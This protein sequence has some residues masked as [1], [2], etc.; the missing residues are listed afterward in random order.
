M[1]RL[2]LILFL[3][4]LSF[5]A[6]AQMDTEHWFAPMADFSNPGTPNQYLYLSTNE[7]T[8]FT[9]YVYSKNQLITTINNLSKGNP[10][11]YSIPRD[12][13]ITSN[14]AEVNNK[15]ALGLHVTGDKKFFANIRFSV[16]SHAEIITSKGKSAL[17]NQFFVGMGEQ[18]LN[19]STSTNNALN[20]MVGIIATEN[21][22]KI[23]LS[24]YNPEVV[25]SDG[26][27]DDSKTIILNKGESYI[28]E[29]KISEELSANL[30][31]LIGAQINADKPISVTNGNFLSLAENQSNVDILMDQSVPIERIGTDYVVLKG[32]GSASGTTISGSNVGFMEKVLVIATEN[33]TTVFV[34]D[35]TSPIVTLNKGEFYIIR[36]KF[37]NPSSN[38]YNLYIKTSKPTYV[39]QLLAGTNGSQGTPEFA[40]GGFNFI[41]ALSCYLPNKID[42][43]GLVNE[44]PYQNYFDHYANTK[45]NIITE[46]GAKV[47]INGGA[48][49][50]ASGP[51][52]IKGNNNWETYVVNN[53]SDNI[54]VNS[55][56]AVTAGI[57]SGSGAVGYGG[58]FAGFNSIPVINKGG[59]CD[60]GFTLEVDNSY[61]SY[62]WYYNGTPYTGPGATSYLINPTESGAYTVVISKNSCGSVTTP[63]YNFIACSLYSKQEFTIG[64]CNTVIIKPK[65]TKSSQNI[66]LSS[67]KI[68]NTPTNGS[69]N[70]NAT[71]GEITYTVTNAN[72]TSDQF[73]FYFSGDDAEFPDAE[74]VVVNLTIKPLKIYNGTVKACVNNGLGR[75]N[76]D[77]V[78]LTD[79]ASAKYTYFKTYDA[80][81]NLDLS[82]EITT[83]HPYLSNVGK[84]Y[85]RITDSFNCYKIAEIDLVDSQPNVN[86]NNYDSLHCDDDFDGIINIKFNEISPLIVQNYQDFSI[87]YF[88]DPNFNGAPLPN[89]W[90]YN[91]DTNVYVRVFSDTACVTAKGIIHFKIAEKIP[92]NDIIKQV[93]D[94]DFNNTETIDLR[95]YLSYVT[96]ETGYTYV[97]YASKTDA[98]KEQNPLDNT[99]KISSESI[100]F[101]KLKKK[102]FCDNITSIKL[103]FRQPTK[104]N[105]P[106]VITICEG[107]TTNLDAGTEFSAYLWNTGETSHEIKNVGKGDYT[108]LL[109]STNG[110][111]FT[112]KVSVV[113]SP[114]PIVDITKFNTT[115]CDDNLDGIIEVNLNRVTAAI[116]LNP[117]IYSVKYYLNSID[118]NDG[119]S[120]IINTD[121]NWTYTTNTTIYVRIESSYC[122]AQI[123][124]LDFKFGTKISLISKDVFQ[125]ECDDNLDGIKSVNLDA[126]KTLFTTDPSVDFSYYTQALDA[127]KKQNPISSNQSVKTNQVFYVRIESP[128]QCADWAKITININIPSASNYLEDKQI[129]KN[130]TTDLDAG[131]GFQYKWS[132]GETTRLVYNKGIGTYYV[133]LEAPNGCVYRQFVNITATTEPIIENILEQG[134]SIIVNVSGGTAPYEYSL[135]QINWQ[136]SNTFSNLKRG[137]Q[138]AYVRDA[139]KCTILEKEFLIINLINAITPNGDGNNEVLD[140]SDLRIKKDVKFLIYDRYGNTVHQ[141]INSQKYIWDGSVNGRMV[142]TGTYWYILSWIEPDTGLPISY[143]GWV[144]VK[145]RN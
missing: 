67:I 145:N 29:A 34:N 70:I 112:Q 94:A 58:Y 55:N 100:Y 131:P 80:A 104:S 50:A 85:V 110:C 77:D 14:T 41:P 89:D 72:A 138:K 7:I 25:F 101:V 99:Q 13:I 75:F 15:S 35:E 82:Q 45:L 140:Y 117:G 38:I 120:N 123:Y 62:Q 78:K 88:L 114:K 46:K 16:K 134:N 66:V 30:T 37:Y 132:T 84:I 69:A 121:N 113:E 92:A 124:P 98:I 31:G 83:L 52:P 96:S 143:K 116:L 49:A 103:N 9:V 48:L 20:S 93:C 71:T 17:G 106:S 33:N 79:D 3:F 63:A 122:S 108:V 81:N 59:D 36:N 65:F 102:G 111:T 32:N 68:K 115:I 74:T 87:E 18:Y 135:D 109:T 73:V 86:T 42:E 128:S 47:T 105:L 91:Q 28:F 90:S 60:K 24:G 21:Q 61:D 95:D 76:I 136:T 44:M 10:Q 125:T 130:A 119:N 40:T 2:L 144:L 8:P 12:Y 5:R 137:L 107:G 118:A 129:C 54:T 127:Q 43:I 51:F 64:T 57:A 56:K 97:F 133:D 1:K 4:S 39:Y 142:P 26:S 126:Y 139:L 22:T 11:K 19:K 27:T 141:E 23:T 53:I 6:S